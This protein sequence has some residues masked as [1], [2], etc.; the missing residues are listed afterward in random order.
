MVFERD[1]KVRLKNEPVIKSILSQPGVGV[2]GLGFGV[3]GLGFGVWGLGF[4]V[5]GLGQFDSY[6]KSHSIESMYILCQHNSV[7]ISALCFTIINSVYNV[8]EY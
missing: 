3:W 2:W 5:W 1:F 6:N 7:C 8:I 4:G